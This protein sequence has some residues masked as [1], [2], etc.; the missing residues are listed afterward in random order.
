LTI[1][2]A[3]HVLDEATHDFLAVYNPSARAIRARLGGIPF[4]PVFTFRVWLS[5]LIAG[6]IV[7][8]ILTPAVQ[9]QRRW[10]L[11]LA[12]VYATIHVLNAFGHLGSSMVYGRL[13][14]GVLSSPVL[15][16]AASW[17]IVETEIVRRSAK[18]LDAGAVKD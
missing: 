17:L 8:A 10:L 14:P 18:R 6:V 2:F 11:P 16:C 1:A 13:M 15:L 9:P 5:S 12:Y 7:L 4:P 3:L